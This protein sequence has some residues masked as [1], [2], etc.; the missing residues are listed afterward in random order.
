MKVYGVN[1]SPFVR[2]VLVVCA[3]KGLEYE[4][5]AVMPGSLPPG[6]LDKSPLGKIPALDDGDA[7][8]CDSSVIC[9]YLE[10]QYPKVAVMPSSA[11]DRAR[12]RWL[13][14]FSDSKLVESLAPFFFERKVKGLLGL[15]E[16][17]EEKLTRL[18]AEDIPQ[19][20]TYLESQLPESGFL[21]GDIGIVDI[22]VCS[23]IISGEYGGY[24]VDSD[25]YPITT[26]YFERVKSHPAIASVMEGEQ[27]MI[28]AM[29]G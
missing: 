21:F 29:G 4:H 16:P 12:A 14:E 1:V 25:S 19:C 5:E 13:E 6:Y 18:A 26:S 2:K 20:L 24:N 28:T 3:I 9:A 22:A 10:E 11:K 23:P 27:A 7:S 15:G 17:D 8:M